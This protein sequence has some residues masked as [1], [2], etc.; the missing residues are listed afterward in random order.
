MGND[1]PPEGIGTPAH[2]CIKGSETALGCYRPRALA[3]RP[4]EAAPE[5][6]RRRRRLPA[7]SPAG[8]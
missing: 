6:T 2:P 5:E 7:H 4:E 1:D 8:R 3:A